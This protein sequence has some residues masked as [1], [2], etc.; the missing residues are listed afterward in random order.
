MGTMMDLDLTKCCGSKFYPGRHESSEI[1]IPLISINF[2]KAGVRCQDCHFELV[3]KHAILFDQKYAFLL[4]CTV[5]SSKGRLKMVE[6]QLNLPESEGSHIIAV[7]KPPSGLEFASPKEMDG[8]ITFEK[9]TACQYKT[10]YVGH[11]TFGMMSCGMAGGTSAFM[12]LH[13]DWGTREADCLSSVLLVCM[14]ADKLRFGMTVSAQASLSAGGLSCRFRKSCD[15]IFEFCDKR[16]QLSV[17]LRAP[18]AVN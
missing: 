7:A 17:M 14:P 12:R 3:Q 15:D 2:E 16:V 1:T 4:Q 5:K 13:P 10:L 8:A 11:K 6:V 18:E 9:S